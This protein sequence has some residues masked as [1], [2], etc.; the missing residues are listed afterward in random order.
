M[1]G[2]GLSAV[3]IVMLS[4]AGFGVVSMSYPSHVQVAGG[5]GIEA[6]FVSPGQSFPVAFSDNAGN[7]QTWDSLSISG[8]PSGW[9]LVSNEKTD[10]SLSAT[11]KVPDF[12]KHG[13]YSFKAALAGGAGVS[14]QVGVSIEVKRNLIEVSFVKKSADEF[15]LVGGKII[16]TATI[17]NSSIAPASVR[18]SSTLPGNWY[19]EKS[20]TVGP[21]S[22]QDINLV[23]TPQ[24]SGR[25]E[26]FFQG[27]AGQ[28]GDIVK[29]FSSEV[30]V[31]PT[32]RG[33]LGSPNSGFPFFTF[34]M[35]PFQL[36]NSF[37]GILF[38]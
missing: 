6:G 4:S 36:F 25:K 5:S 30:D 28:K 17:S 10:A 7:G 12:E 15:Y 8:L 14:E 31:K 9:Q 19:R 33:E 26:F 32:F 37:L 18:L 24:T 3:F 35:L 38:Q 1:K 22:T 23:V 21:Q 13:R 16:Y 27:F 29:T 2:L 20:V 34:S 11:I